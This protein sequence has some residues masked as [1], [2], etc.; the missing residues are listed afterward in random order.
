L[1][2]VSFTGGGGASAAVSGVGVI[3]AN[4]ALSFDGKLRDR[5]GR[6]DKALSPDGALDATFTV[7][8]LAGSGNRTVVKLELRRSDNG[9]IWNTTADSRWALGAAATLDGALY[10]NTADASV[11]FAVSEGGSF[12][13]FAS[14][15]TG[16]ANYFPP[17]STFIL[18]ATFGDGSTAA[19]SA[20]VP[21]GQA[22]V[23]SRS[24]ASA[25]GARIK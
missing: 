2:H 12:K 23:A 18:T 19:A 14:N 7:N 16:S 20:T 24:K 5:V 13:L 8:L 10:N 25:G 11:N 1:S 17:G 3:P 6:A 21:S 4:L 9:G 22:T 15:G